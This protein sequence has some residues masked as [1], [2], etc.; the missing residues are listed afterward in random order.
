MYQ[1]YLKNN[2]RYI[3]G[4]F[5]LKIFINLLKKIHQTDSIKLLLKTFKRLKKLF[6]NLLKLEISI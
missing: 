3:Q 4:F 5:F 6:K 2:I 1:K